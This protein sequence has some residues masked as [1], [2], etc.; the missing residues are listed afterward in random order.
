MRKKYRNETENNELMG[1]FLRWDP[2]KLHKDQKVWR[3]IIM[4][5]NNER[6][7]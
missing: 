2:E 6:E 7:E 4:R 5:W 1:L 3:E